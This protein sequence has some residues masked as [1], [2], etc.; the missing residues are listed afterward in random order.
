MLVPSNNQFSIETT[1]EEKYAVSIFL[2]LSKAFDTVNH[3]ILLSKLDLYGIRGDENQ[4][5]RSYQAAGSRKF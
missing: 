4:W 5:F 1:D 3:S 2:D